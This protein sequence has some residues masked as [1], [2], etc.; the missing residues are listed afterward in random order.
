MLQGLHSTPHE[1][2]MQKVKCQAK[3]QTI[4]AWIIPIVSLIPNPYRIIRHSQRK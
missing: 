2:K 1:K 4:C 3:C